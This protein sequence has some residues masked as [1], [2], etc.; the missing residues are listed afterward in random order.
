MPDGG[1]VA[2]GAASV[3]CLRGFAVEDVRVEGHVVEELATGFVLLRLNGGGIVRA[4]VLESLEQFLVF[5]GNAVLL[6]SHLALI[7][8][9]DPMLS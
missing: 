3:T 2:G 4:S 5:E 7:E 8:T 6:L 1:G 9:A